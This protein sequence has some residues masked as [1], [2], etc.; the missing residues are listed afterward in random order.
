MNPADMSDRQV[1]EARRMRAKVCEENPEAIP[2]IQSLVR[3]GLI[4]GW[5][6]VVWAG[7][8]REGDDRHARLFQPRTLTYRQFKFLGMKEN[9][10]WTISAS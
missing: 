1:D 9:Q 2:F 4:R 10:K 7:S 3:E 8:L 6:D 5:R